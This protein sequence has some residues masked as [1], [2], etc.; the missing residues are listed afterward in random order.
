MT[1]WREINMDQM[2]AELRRFVKVTNGQ[3]F[4]WLSQL[5][6]RWDEQQR[7][8]LANICDVHFFYSYQYLGNTPRLVITPSLA[9]ATSLR[10]SLST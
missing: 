1:K 2:G 5:R 6:H 9:G 3:A 4:Y 10:P 8:C 7:H